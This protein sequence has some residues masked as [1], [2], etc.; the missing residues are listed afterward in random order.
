MASVL[1]SVAAPQHSDLS[2]MIE[3]RRVGDG[4]AN[5]GP[6]VAGEVLGYGDELRDLE[7]AAGA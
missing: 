2:R 4:C 1:H 7:I 6:G 5:L 3:W